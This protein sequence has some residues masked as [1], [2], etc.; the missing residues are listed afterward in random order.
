MAQ[1]FLCK[2]LEIIVEI[3][4][5]SNLMRQS[6]IELITNTAQK[7]KFSIKDFSSR[8]K[9]NSQ[10]CGVTARENSCCKNVHIKNSF[11]KYIQ[12]MPSP[13]PKKHRQES[14]FELFILELF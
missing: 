7:M 8:S 10:Y 5:V 14:F 4:N 11:E 2:V 3:I 9:E 6:R 1:F 13:P 12:T